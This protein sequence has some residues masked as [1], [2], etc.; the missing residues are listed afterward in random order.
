MHYHRSL[1]VLTLAIGLWSAAGCCITCTCSSGMLGG[2][3][4]T[5]DPLNATQKCK[6][7]CAPR[8]GGGTVKISTECVAAPVNAQSIP[9][10]DPRS[11]D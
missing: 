4:I 1:T 5:Q 2:P 3:F 6:T 8:G 9:T 10:P 7:D 11:A